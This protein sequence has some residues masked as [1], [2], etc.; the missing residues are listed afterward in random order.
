MAEDS[1]EEAKAAKARGL[2]K[3]IRQLI[4]GEKPASDEPE[5]ESPRDF[6]HRRM[7]ERDHD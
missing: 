4:A 3:R 1:D 2:R 7:R 6:I 5:V